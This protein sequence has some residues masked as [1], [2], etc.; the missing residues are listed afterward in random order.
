MGTST[1]GPRDRQRQPQ[2]VVVATHRYTILATV[3]LQSRRPAPRGADATS[4]TRFVAVG[5]WLSEAGWS[6]RGL[7]HAV[8]ARRFRLIQPAIRG[9]EHFFEAVIEAES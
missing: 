2:F 6:D 3:R 4:Q 5:R 1:M 8:A 9:G 7:H